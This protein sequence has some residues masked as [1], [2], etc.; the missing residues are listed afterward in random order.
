MGELNIDEF[1]RMQRAPLRLPYAPVGIKILLY[2]DGAMSFEGPTVDPDYCIEIMEEA[3]HMMRRQKRLAKQPKSVIITPGEDV[4]VK[5][6]RF[7]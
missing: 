1:E 5:P 6:L 3:I 7:L 4:G 2:P